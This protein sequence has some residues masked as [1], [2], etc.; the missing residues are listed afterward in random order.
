MVRGLLREGLRGGWE[1]F[2]GWLG[3]GWILMVC[4]RMVD[5]R[6]VCK[7]GGVWRIIESDF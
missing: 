5:E 2:F 3:D 1:E 7:V 4:K 6:G